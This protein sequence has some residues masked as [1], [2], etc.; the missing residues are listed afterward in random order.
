MA[1]DFLCGLPTLKWEGTYYPVGPKVLVPQSAFFDTSTMGKKKRTSL[2]PGEGG[3]LGSLTS[4]EP[5]GRPGVGPQFIL[6]CLIG[7]E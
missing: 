4:R 1:V 2:L 5:L 3:N 6:L 7:V